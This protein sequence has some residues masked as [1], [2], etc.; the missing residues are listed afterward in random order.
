M[1]IYKDASG[2]FVKGKYR[3][4]MTAVLNLGISIILVKN[5]GLA[6][7]FL[8]SIISR[9]VT[10]WWYDA[11]LLYRHGF[12]KSPLPYFRNCLSTMILIIVSTAIVQRFTL[13]W[14][15]ATWPDIVIKGILCVIVVNGI[16]LLI[17]GR[18]K[19]FRY[20]LSKVEL[21]LKKKSS[22]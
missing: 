13:M 1:Q 10:T 8:G 4:V 14:Q 17:Y 21:I 20:L 7:V 9:M 12:H 11:W 3:A 22:V 6:G 16:Y 18:S 15:G 5:I 2:L 19:E